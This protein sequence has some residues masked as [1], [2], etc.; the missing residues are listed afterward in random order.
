MDKK[1]NIRSK[2]IC[3]I[4]AIFIA[5]PV[6]MGIRFYVR[7]IQPWQGGVSGIERDFERNR[8][9][10]FRVRD[11]LAELEYDDVFIPFHMERGIMSVN[12]GRRTP[13]EN[14]QIVS[15]I[16]RLRRRGYRSISK[17]NNVISFTRV[18]FG[19]RARGVAY[20]I[21]RE[22]PCELAL[23]FL[24]EIEP[25]NREGWYFFEVDFNVWRVRRQD[26]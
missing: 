5:I 20:S 18:S 4:L 9:L 25:L 17:R 26:E 14:A 15:A 23:T 2:I 12:A 22:V 3:V 7:R 8:E 16:E 19:D 24:I 6:I 21:D 1:K 13:I 11:Y 10:I